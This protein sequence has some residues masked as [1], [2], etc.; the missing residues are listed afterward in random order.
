ML[1]KRMRYLT[2]LFNSN[3]LAVLYSCFIFA[4]TSAL[5]LS[6][7][8]FIRYVVDDG[9]N[10]GSYRV[11]ITYVL[12]YVLFQILTVIMG[13]YGLYLSEKSAHTILWKEKTRF[14]NSIYS[15]PY[16]AVEHMSSA[17]V[18]VL[19]NT[20]IDDLKFF[21]ADL[22]RV[23]VELG[24]LILG[25]LLVVQIMNTTALA[26]IIVAVVAN[27][28]LYVF[29]Q[30]ILDKIARE[31]TERNKAW[32]T[33]LYSLLQ[34]TNEYLINSNWGK[35]RG[36]TKKNLKYLVHLEHKN[37]WATT[38]SSTLSN[39]LSFS[40]TLCIYLF[41][42]SEA[43]IGTVISSIA[44]AGIIFPLIQTCI[45]MMNYYTMLSPSIDEVICVEDTPIETSNPPMERKSDETDHYFIENL[46]FCYKGSYLFREAE[47]SLPKRGIVNLCSPNGR[48]KT[49]LANII[50]GLIHPDTGRTNL[51][52]EDI[53]YMPQTAVLFPATLLFNI[54]LSEQ[55]QELSREIQEF[56]HLLRVD[57][58]ILKKEGQYNTIVSMNEEGFSGGEKRKIC[59]LRALHDG[60]DKPVI[61][62]DEPDSG[63]DTDAI[64]NLKQI[65]L[66]LSSTK[67]IIIITHHHELAE[68]GE[69]YILESGKIIPGTVL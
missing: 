35:I 57:D 68:W 7:T 51:I 46:T 54:T 60:L 69:R 19:I 15:Q 36:I 44:F 65:I 55:S 37:H 64:R 21:F 48:G 25:S 58:F 26:I 41:T 11:T 52:K 50:A 30:K 27:A 23:L 42:P 12:L 28:F 6:A 62:L 49:T 18:N 5:S 8:L 39:I 29:F 2:R 43:S 61:L 14:L 31:K 38:T 4:I 1:R 53:A 67:L 17:E 56:M 45:D 32:S 47:W 24:C 3:M 66:K 59:L 33:W 63:L 22:P 20:H 34:H 16:Q 40:L 9:I 13:T 10:A